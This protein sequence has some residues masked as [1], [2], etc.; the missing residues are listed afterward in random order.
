MHPLDSSRLKLH[1]AKRHL[2][3]LYSDQRAFYGSENESSSSDAD[4]D[5]GTELRHKPFQPPR[6]GPWS[7]VVG[8]AVHNMRCSL[9]HI[10]YA[11]AVKH[12]AAIGE[13]RKPSGDTTFPLFQNVDKPGFR[14]KTADISPEARKVIEG[15]Q[16]HNRSNPLWMVSV[17]DNADKHRAITI[18]GAR[19]SMTNITLGEGTTE[20]G[21]AD[22]RIFAIDPATGQPTKDL[23]PKATTSVSLLIKVPGLDEP[24]I[25]T[26]LLEIHDFIRDRV[27]PAFTSFFP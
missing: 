26:V 12:L 16:P 17:L 19:I 22:G 24:V 27:F 25:D 14:K 21:L 13:T 20:I 5:S 6:V 9:D 3:L 7:M 18:H 2:D 15:F 8:D 10:A 23:Q 4:A 1:W 11:L